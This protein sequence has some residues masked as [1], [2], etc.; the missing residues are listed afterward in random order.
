MGALTLPLTGRVYVDAQIVIYAVERHPLYAPAIL[1]LW[2]AVA[3]GEA[4][5][6]TSELTLMEVLVGPI[7][8]DDPSLEVDFERLL[9]GPDVEMVPVGQGALRYAAGLRAVNPSLRT[10][11]AI[12][13]A[14]AVES[15]CTAFLTNDRRLG[16]AVDAVPTIVLDEV[17]VA[18]RAGSPSGE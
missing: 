14:T 17:I 6:V 15:G 13:L 10:P 5:V 16:R 18:G 1:P 9:L 7:A 4:K 3:N 8:L 12:H 11:D 2:Q